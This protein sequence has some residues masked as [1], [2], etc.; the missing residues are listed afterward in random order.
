MKKLKTFKI[1]NVFV[2]INKITKKNNQI[3]INNLKYKNLLY[4][5]KFDFFIEDTFNSI[6]HSIFFTSYI[7][8]PLNNDYEFFKFTQFESYLSTLELFDISLGLK[9]FDYKYKYTLLT[10][11]IPFLIKNGKKLKTINNLLLAISNIYRALNNESL[12]KD[13]AFINEFKY[14]ILTSKDTNN[15]NFLLN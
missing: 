11:F 5:N 8:D 12:L 13:Y 6:D 7:S 14:Y 1:D 15:L 9:K 2:N 4:Y 3:Q 10:R